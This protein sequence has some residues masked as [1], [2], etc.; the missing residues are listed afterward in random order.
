MVRH[1]ESSRKGSKEMTRNLKALGLSL[2]AV[3]ALGAV[4]ASSALAVPSFT[5]PELAAGSNS[6]ITGEQL[7]GTNVFGVKGAG[8]TTSCE[9]AT[10][11]GTVTGTAAAEVTVRPTFLEKCLTGGKASPVDVNGCAF[12]LK[13]ATTK[14]TD[15]EGKAIEVAGATLECEGTKEIIITASGCEIG[16]G[17]THANEPKV[18]LNHA[19]DGMTYK[20]E[21][22]GAARDIKATVEIDNITYTSS[23]GFACAIGGLKE[24]GND[25]F[26]T[27][28]VTVKAF[29]HTGGTP[30]PNGF[31]DFTACEGVQTAA[32]HDDV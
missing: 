12:V 30:C 8:L 27:T 6:I 29:K 3:C 11:A 21:G 19:L 32:V 20:N 10:Y 2:L 23:G 14:S 15:T 26:L 4:A 5:T 24:T 28:T 25:A 1:A 9:K 16:I 17:T 13:A 7:A 31:D 22:A 18:V